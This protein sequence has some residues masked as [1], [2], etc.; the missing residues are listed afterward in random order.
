MPCNIA[1]RFNTMKSI[2]KLL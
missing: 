1:N 2:S